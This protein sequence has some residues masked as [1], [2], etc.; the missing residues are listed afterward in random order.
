M[1]YKILSILIIKYFLLISS[2]LSQTNSQPISDE[3]LRI[4][5]STVKRSVSLSNPDTFFYSPSQDA[6]SEYF[7]LRDLFKNPIYGQQFACRYPARYLT[8]K[9]HVAL[10]NYNLESCKELVNFTRS[11]PKKHLSLAL[12]TE[13]FG[14]P[15]SL[16]GHVMLVFHNDEHPEADASAVH[17]AAITDPEIGFSDYIW[18]G[19]SGGF[20][21]TF[22]RE[23]LFKKRH[24]YLNIE[25]RY[26]FYYR[27]TLA[28]ETI[29]LLLYHLYELRGVEFKYY[30]FTAN[31]AQQLSALIAAVTK[32]EKLSGTLYNLPIEV[33]YQHEHAIGSHQFDT[34]DIVKLRAVHKRLTPDEHARFKLLQTE[35][36]N[37]WRGIETASDDLKQSLSLFYEYNF[38]RKRLVLQNYKTVSQLEFKDSLENQQLPILDP[39]DRPRP[40]RLT[41]AFQKRSQDHHYLLGFRPVITDLKD[42]QFPSMQELNMTI[43][44]SQVRFA[45]RRITL[46]ELRLLELSMLTPFDFV[47]PTL[48]WGAYFGLSRD[49]QLRKLRWSTNVS[50][51]LTY[52]PTQNVGFNAM[53]APGFDVSPAGFYPLLMPKTYFFA[54]LGRGLK[55]TAQAKYKF[56]KVDRFYRADIR[57]SHYFS[58]AH[59]GVSGGFE[60]TNWFSR[61]GAFVELLYYF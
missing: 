17:F 13:Y 28:P 50:L 7:T 33:L 47:T 45:N 48:S 49:N 2:V 32:E 23:P 53:I 24:E 57:L 12:S 44:D 40:R 54:Y 39:L 31:C 18:K 59:L 34:P 58:N 46:E 41:M 27:L 19:I 60:T 6:I 5:H 14:S 16:F 56:S 26:I 4:T 21:G 8:I 10:P 25:Q 9:K 22:V 52:M 1:F 29:Q 15:S 36:H 20:K 61:N 11:F 42:F 3:W 43:L 30:F 35:D 38:R 55:L 37:A 51:G